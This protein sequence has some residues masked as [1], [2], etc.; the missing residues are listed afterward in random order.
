[1]ADPLLLALAGFPT[2]VIRPAEDT[3]V[4]DASSK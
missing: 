1:M 2:E 4:T 3:T